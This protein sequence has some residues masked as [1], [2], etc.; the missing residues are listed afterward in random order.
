MRFTPALFK[1][2]ETLLSELLRS[3]FPAG[4]LA[5]S[6]AGLY[7]LH[8]IFSFDMGDQFVA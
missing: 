5:R 3:T 8:N 6:A 1:H 7:P 2:T 4:F